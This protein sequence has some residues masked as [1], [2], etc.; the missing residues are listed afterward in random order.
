M[1][2]LA[3]IEK[4]LTTQMIESGELPLGPMEHEALGLKLHSQEVLVSVAGGDHFYAQWSG[5]GRRL[6]GETLQESLQLNA[7]VDDLLRLCR[8]PD[9]LE[10]VVVPAP[11][12]L[13][14][15]PRVFETPRTPLGAARPP[16]Q[17]ARKRA[18]LIGDRF[19][20]R[21]HD[22]YAW[23]G[24]IGLHIKTSQTFAEHMRA[25][26]WDPAEM[27]HLRLEGERLAVLDNF[28][29][30]LATAS[31][32]IDPLPYQEA[33]AR[34]ALSRMQGRAI[35][36]DEVG[37]GKTIEAGLVM[38]E[39]VLR[40]LVRRILIIT[41]ATL[42]DQWE[43]ELREKFEEQFSIA[44]SS[45]NDLQADRV[46]MSLQLALRNH[47][48]LTT[49]GWDLVIVDEAHKLAGQNATA[50]RRFMRALKSRYL[51]FLSATP[52]QN[53][54]LELYRLVDLLKPGTFRS[55]ADFARRFVSE[56]DRRQPVRP[57]ELRQLVSNVMVR[58]TREQAGLDK[59]T[60][61]ATDRPF[62]LSPE[63]LALYHF[64]TETLRSSMTDPGDSLRRRQLAHRL[65]A[66][67]RSMGATA[68]RMAETHPDPR[69]QQALRE[70]GHLAH[71]VRG[72]AREEVA[73]DQIRRWLA[74]HG[75]VL[76][77]SQHTDTVEA[78]LR[79][80]DLEGTAAKPFHGGLSGSAKNEAIAWFKAAA[81]R[82]LV[83][84]DAG[85]EG[86]NLQFCN[87]VLNFDLPW[88]P[89]R[90]EQR[91][92]R[93]HRVTQTRD[94]HISNLFARD[95]VDE[96]VYELLHDKLRMFELLFGQVTTILGELDPTDGARTFEGRILEALLAPSDTT[97][98]QRLTALGKQ[99][100][101]AR[102]RAD[103]MVSAGSHINQWA[104][105]SDRHA[106]RAHIPVGGAA[107][108]RPKIRDRE[109]SRQDQLRRFIERFL[110]ALGAD[111]THASPNFL[112]AA[113]PSDL[114]ADFP[115]RTELHLAFN[116]A[117]LDEHSDAE[118]CSVGSEVFEEVLVALRL[119]GDLTASV[120]QL[121]DMTNVDEP[122]HS[123]GIRLISR[124][125][126]RTWAA[127]AH[128]KI[129]TSDQ[130]T[131]ETID[132]I[133]AGDRT[134]PTMP[135]S[136][137]LGGSHLPE[138]IS[139]PELIVKAVEQAAVDHLQSRVLEEQEQLLRRIEA[140]RD[141]M[142]DYFVGQLAD[143]RGEARRCRAGTQ[144]WGEVQVGIQQIER[145][146]ATYN[147][148]TAQAVEIRA[149]LTAVEILAGPN[150]D[151]VEVWQKQDSGAQSEITYRWSRRPGSPRYADAHGLIVT[152]DLCSSGHPVDASRNRRCPC[153]GKDWCASCGPDATFLPCRTCSVEVCGSCLRWGSGSCR[154]CSRPT[155]FPESDTEWLIAWHLGGDLL[156][157]VGD[158]VAEIHGSSV[159][160]RIVVPTADVA[161][162]LRR[163][164]RA[165][166]PRIDIPM[167]TGVVVDGIPP[168]YT[169][170]PTAISSVVEH[171]ATFAVEPHGGGAV[172][173][174]AAEYLAP[175][176]VEDEVVSEDQCGL[177]RLLAKLRSQVP[178]PAA[179]LIRLRPFTWI[180]EVRVTTDGLSRRWGMLGQDRDDTETSTSCWREGAPAWATEGWSPLPL[181]LLHAEIA[182]VE[183]VIGATG[184]DVI[185]AVR[186]E[187]QVT[188]LGVKQRP[189]DLA[190]LEMGRATCGQDVLLAVGRMTSPS[191][192]QG[193]TVLGARRESRSTSMKIIPTH[194]P[195]PAL[196][197]QMVL[198][199]WFPQLLVTRPRTQPAPAALAGGVLG[200]LQDRG[201]FRQRCYVDIGAVVSE[202]WVTDGGGEPFGLSYELAP[203]Q[204]QGLI[205]DFVTGQDA[206]AVVRDRS[207]H[208]VASATACAY[209]R[210][211]TC[212]RCP[213]SAVSCAGCGIA[214][215]GR[216][217]GATVG[218][219]ASYC[220]ACRSP[221][222][223]T[224]LEVASLGLDL[225]RKQAPLFAS[226]PAH[227]LA[228]VAHPERGVWACRERRPDGSTRDFVLDTRVAVAMAGW[229]ASHQQQL[230]PVAW[231]RGSSPPP[232][233]S[234]GDLVAHT[235]TRHDE[236]PNDVPGH[237][238]YSEA[239]VG[240]LVRAVAHLPAAVAVLRLTSE[241]P[242]QWLRFDEVLAAADVSPARARGQLSA[243]SRACKSAGVPAWPVQWRWGPDGL[244][245]YR[246]DELMATWIRRAL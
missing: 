126:R 198:Q 28:E 197:T 38:K 199:A 36:A 177:Q 223:A 37:L 46:I 33:T 176:P 73:V 75:R 29:E 196:A 212:P 79:R 229:L 246:A 148:T 165:M 109:G 101:A 236:A 218:G 91:I 152:L 1:F 77:F 88:N 80:L 134:R 211:L 202:R 200:T 220:P 18:K 102:K 131:G 55:S 221:R 90:I 47:D 149:E 111:I 92:G 17:E 2:E 85:A 51:L 20:L 222:P 235:A 68:L 71:E 98:G 138:E 217:A 69:V 93:V 168:E 24:Q 114:R 159:P 241:R 74:E 237:S 214:V 230:G 49:Q 181:T 132:V 225:E 215:C 65:T 103:Q 178:P 99:L 60:R 163:H 169:E 189:D 208:L 244:I 195:Q 26:G 95:T 110:T 87:A 7:R 171:G 129:G 107:E 234:D 186:T 125:L 117:G 63:E 204:T 115:G 32:H 72:S 10:M 112:T 67:P 173:P 233:P 144:R 141:R 166:G 194:A 121:P 50:T 14:V 4:R 9:G 128:W 174:A 209:C 22:E 76:V 30:L 94:V 23:T 136:P 78:I 96:S 139:S 232:L 206:S 15:P 81:G 150:F 224:R 213:A 192:V 143:L 137:L 97:M 207:G 160:P 120:T 127:Q 153:C 179:P 170:A 145:A 57:Q 116:R 155:R 104:S 151:V 180:D 226:D 238:T 16:T 25:G 31:A 86:L 172:D 130:S 185:L 158:G 59:V 52:V 108:L 27:V 39:L 40:G 182:D 58:T 54:L 205:R 146:R 187:G 42:R 243:F 6:G 164:L 44:T 123:G 203:G 133:R 66:S 119:R 100:E 242:G 82:V 61:Y 140:E 201:I 83:S 118:L 3:S 190:A 62:T 157:L 41:P 84:T 184:E 124:T 12:G 240:K 43:A 34:E 175:V 167:S 228:W 106:H 105:P 193:P 161:N 231:R 191:S 53:D 216:C 210:G 147:E 135:A 162:P 13:H 8:I 64:C 21:S 45:W 227:A 19:R 5:R 154:S 89:M 56:Q 142:E 219:G 48:R 11:R 35:L 183:A 188:W 122:A 113:L 245:E 70:L 239:M 156:L